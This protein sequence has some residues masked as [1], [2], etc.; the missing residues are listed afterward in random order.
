MAH[1]PVRA[2]FQVRRVS[3]I[4]PRHG[5]CVLVSK[6]D[7]LRE[8]EVREGVIIAHSATELHVKFEKRW[9]IDNEKWRYGKN[10]ILFETKLMPPIIDLILVH[11]IA[12]TLA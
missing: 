7:P 11:L 1:F 4:V 2:F 10:P 6:V 12:R 9:N 5:M 8:E 3:L